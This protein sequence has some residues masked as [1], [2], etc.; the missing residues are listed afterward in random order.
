MA[1][2]MFITGEWGSVAMKLD[3]CRDGTS[4]IEV[5][6][7]VTGAGVLACPDPEAAFFAATGA[8]FDRHGTLPVILAGMIGSNIGWQ[9]SGYVDCP[10]DA[11]KVA[12]ASTPI[13]ARGIKIH[14]TPGLKCR[15]IFGLPDVV[16]GEEMQVFGWLARQN[17]QDRRL[18]CLPGRHTKWL[19]TQGRSIVSFFTGMT[20]EL[21]DLLLTHGLLGKGVVRDAAAFDAFAAGLDLIA[22]DPTLSLGHALFA[23]RSRLV[24]GDHA[25]TEAAS[26]L[27][28]LMIGADVRDSVKA[29]AARGL[30]ATRVAVLGHGRTAE[31]YMAAFARLDIP[32]EPVDTTGLAVDGL[33]A[34]L[35]V[36]VQTA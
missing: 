9:D 24:L 7:T 18:V 8:W 34:L 5:L 30:P 16:R 3:L 1:S 22:A 11:A 17:D 12:A 15:N 14:F 20:G 33:A 10:G 27:K 32:A 31:P 35:A 6:E 25:A 2:N 36:A 26:F 13:V 29:H 28:G 19:M 23:T 21:E 4:G